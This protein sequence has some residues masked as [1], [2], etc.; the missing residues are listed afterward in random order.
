M[1]PPMPTHAHWNAIL[2]ED[3]WGQVGHQVVEEVWLV[4]KQLWGLLLHSGLQSLCVRLRHAIP[5]L[6]LPPAGIES[7]IIIR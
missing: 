7:L 2:H 3:A 5:R 6:G 4:L 1:E